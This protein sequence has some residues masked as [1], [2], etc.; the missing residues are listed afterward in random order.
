MKRK[1]TL[2]QRIDHVPAAKSR[3]AEPLDP[4]RLAIDA[5]S[6]LAG[7]PARLADF[8][9]TT[10]LTRDTLRDAADRPG[11]LRGVLDYVAADEALLVAFAAHQGVSPEAVGH[12]VTAAGGGAEPTP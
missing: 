5:L 11:F 2:V 3:K 8:L 4:D 12:A 9:A 10:G 7:E 1:T 6:Y